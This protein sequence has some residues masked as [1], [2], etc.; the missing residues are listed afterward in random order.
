[1]EGVRSS[2]LSAVLHGVMYVFIGQLKSIEWS[3]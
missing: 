2:R 1:M 3:T